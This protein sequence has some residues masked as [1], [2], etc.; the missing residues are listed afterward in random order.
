MRKLISTSTAPQPAGTYSQAVL[1][2]GPLLYISGQTPRLPDGKLLETKNIGAQTSQVLKNIVNIAE[3][4][5]MSLSDAIHLTVYLSDMDQ[6]AE[7]E[8]AYKHFFSD[9]LPARIVVQSSLKGFDVE[10]SAILQKSAK[11][12]DL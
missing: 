3:A 4:A 11:N 5:E 7:F 10:I 9:S 12:S 2:G 8:S 1:A 6:K